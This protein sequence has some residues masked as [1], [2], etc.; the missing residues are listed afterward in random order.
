MNVLT[1]ETYFARYRLMDAKEP[2]NIFVNLHLL[3]LLMPALL[4]ENKFA[5][6]TMARVME[7]VGATVRAME[8]VG[9]MTEGSFPAHNARH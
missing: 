8:R 1:T 9:A 6:K 4:M 7:R 3:L 2:Q 5:W